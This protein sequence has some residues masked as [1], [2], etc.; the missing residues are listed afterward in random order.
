MWSVMITRLLLFRLRTKLSRV[1]ALAK[2]SSADP[3]TASQIKFHEESLVL[4]N[5]TSTPQPYPN[6]VA[7]SV[8]PPRARSASR[9]RLVNSAKPRL[10]RNNPESVSL[11][12]LEEAHTEI[13]AL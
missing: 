2:R 11:G 6:E 1:I 5:G 12:L 4:P 13:C 9:G 10:A 7:A 8:N 3:N